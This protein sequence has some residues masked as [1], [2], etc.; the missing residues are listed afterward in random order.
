[1]AASHG[2]S[3]ATWGSYPDHEHEDE[4][5][6]LAGVPRLRFDEVGS[7]VSFCHSS[8][9]IIQ[10][11]HCNLLQ[12]LHIEVALH[13]FG[14]TFRAGVLMP[15]HYKLVQCQTEFALHLFGRTFG[16]VLMH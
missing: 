2:P 12:L 4:S 14:R 1:M 7:A 13:L 9:D 6:E 11:L 10:P 15:L 3:S 5:S 8:G 16:A